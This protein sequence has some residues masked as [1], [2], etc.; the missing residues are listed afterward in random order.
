MNVSEDRT[1]VTILILTIACGVI[2]GNIYTCQPLLHAIAVDF[3][4]PEKIASAVAVATQIGYAC[5]ILL[6][7]PLSDV[8]DPKTFVRWLIGLT[9]LGL[10][11]A[12][13]APNIAVLTVASA[14]LA[15]TTV[16]PQVL[17]PLSMS[18][19]SPERRG[20]TVGTLTLGLVLGILLS[21]TV[22]GILAEYSGSW[23]TSFAVSSI[24]TLVLFFALPPF[25][26]NGQAPAQPVGYFSLLR[27]IPPLLVHRPLLLSM[28]MNFL[29]F[30]A[31]SAFWAT[32]AFHLA[33]PA[34]L[35]GPAAAGLFGLWGAPGTLIAPQVG[36]I[37]DRVGSNAINAA[38]F[39]AILVCF[40]LALTLGS[41]SI[42]GLV[43]AV[44]L[45]DF[46]VQSGQVAN[47]SRI[48]AIAP[49]FR[50]RLNTIYMFT[51]FSGGAIGA[52]GGALAWT[53]FGWTGVCTMG[54]ILVC[55]AAVLLG[56]AHIIGARRQA[57]ASF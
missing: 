42:P 31:F 32:L 5:G 47:Q 43:I 10:L 26:K 17:I 54:I 34:F 23:R 6:L 50:G 24:S 29:V 1:W 9:F 35:L 11:A 27:S 36:R 12:T 14:C 15:L 52:M 49:E 55:L 46:G 8:A 30:G 4:V 37:V 39:A 25:L 13:A 33:S 2:V 45:L 22:S 16:V 40:I 20:R 53:N 56:V 38:A 7:V 28:G 44:N 57:Y 18:L 19:V 21:R 3:G 41:H 51:T 48:F